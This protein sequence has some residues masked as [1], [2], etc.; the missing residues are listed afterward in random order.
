MLTQQCT[1]CLQFEHRIPN[2]VI[3]DAFGWQFDRIALAT[4]SFVITPAAGCFV[5]GYLLII[6]KRHV[7]SIAQLSCEELIEIE[8]IK[9]KISSYY[10]QFYKVS[11]TFFEHGTADS[12]H[13]A[14]SCIAHAHLHA[15][16][17]QV[18]IAGTFIKHYTT[19]TIVDAELPR[20]YATANYLYISEQ[21]RILITSLQATCRAPC[22]YFRRLAADCNSE[23]GKWDWRNHLYEENFLITLNDAKLCL[24]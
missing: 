15:L 22:Q 5:L 7:T 19:K 11:A 1:F 6:P 12:N 8:G 9:S 10:Q 17:L 24:K 4:K 3:L 18:P 20:N 23:K 13:V 2:G 14:P 21:D 16:P